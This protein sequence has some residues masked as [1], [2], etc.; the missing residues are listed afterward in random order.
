[1]KEGC[2]RVTIREADEVAYMKSPKNSRTDIF[3]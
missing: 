1:M 3:K 2:C